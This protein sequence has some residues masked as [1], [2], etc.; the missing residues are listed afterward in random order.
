MGGEKRPARP[1]S[2]VGYTERWNEVEGPRS[3]A[4]RAGLAGLPDPDLAERQSE[5][6]DGTFERADFTYDRKADAYTCPAGKQL[7]PHQVVYRTPRPLVDEDGMIR[8]HASLG[9]YGRRVSKVLPFPPSYYG[10]FEWTRCRQLPVA[11]SLHQG[12]TGAFL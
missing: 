3:Y 2:R 11:R 1:A 8:Y 12:L 6:S 9:A 4:D 10:L 7:R 5:R